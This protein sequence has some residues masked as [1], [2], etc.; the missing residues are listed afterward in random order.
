MPWPCFGRLG[1]HMD[2]AASSQLQR[3]FIVLSCLPVSSPLL[4]FQKAYEHAFMGI[5]INFKIVAYY[6]TFR[7]LKTTSHLNQ[8]LWI[9]TETRAI[10]CLRGLCVS[11]FQLFDNL[12]HIA[13]IS[14]EFEQESCTWWQKSYKD[15]DYDTKKKFQIWLILKAV[16]TFRSCWYTF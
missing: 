14:K 3:Y 13:L 4:S 6:E 1:G 15:V 8:P 16:M 10:V 11:H 5:I 2:A 9:S 7:V 12:I